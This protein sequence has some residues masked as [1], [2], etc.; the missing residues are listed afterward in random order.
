[1][2]KKYELGFFLKDDDLLSAQNVALFAMLRS[3]QTNQ[4]VLTA[5]CHLLFDRARG[6]IKLAQA[7]LIMGTLR[8]IAS[9]F[10]GRIK[11]I[12]NQFQFYGLEISIPLHDLHSIHIL[13]I[14]HLNI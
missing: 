4:L 9:R 12:E 8:L 5:N 3:K 13:E 7:A 14:H 6:D 1:M 10:N 2:E 11:F